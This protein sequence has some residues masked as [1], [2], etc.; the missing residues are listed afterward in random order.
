ML[1]SIHAMPTD[2]MP[3]QTLHGQKFATLVGETRRRAALDD[4][5][6]RRRRE[7]M[8]SDPKQ[9]GSAVIWLLVF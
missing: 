6:L 3:S 7:R 8:R 1:P 9:P 4:Q 5:P 2:H